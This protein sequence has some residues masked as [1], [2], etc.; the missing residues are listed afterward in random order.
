MSICIQRETPPFLWTLH[1]NLHC[2][3]WVL[4]SNWWWSCY[5]QQS[6]WYSIKGACWR[7]WMNIVKNAPIIKNEVQK[8]S[9]NIDEDCIPYSVS[10]VQETNKILWDRSTRDLQKRSYGIHIIHKIKL[11]WKNHWEVPMFQKYIYIISHFDSYI[12]GVRNMLSWKI[13]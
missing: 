7:W 4:R 10:C 3:Q 6:R 8:I 12:K 1:W 11:L 2:I 5:R 9:M 13:Q